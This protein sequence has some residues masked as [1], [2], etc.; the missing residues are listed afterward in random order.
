MPTSSKDE[1]TLK[2]AGAQ[3]IAPGAVVRLKNGQTVTITRMKD[4]GSFQ[5]QP[6]VKKKARG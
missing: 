2:D 1:S 6:V 5:Y 3:E 4:D